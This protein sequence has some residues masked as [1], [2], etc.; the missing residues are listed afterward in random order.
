MKRPIIVTLFLLLFIFLTNLSKAQT[1]QKY[2]KSGN[3]NLIDIVFVS[4]SRGFTVGYNK[5]FMTTDTGK[6]WN[7]ILSS[8]NN[9]SR[10][11]FADANNG[12]IIGSNDLV[13]KTTDAGDNWSLIRTGNSD[14]DLITLF[15]K[16]KDTL[17]VL[18]PDDMDTYKYG[19]YL[20]YTYNG[21]STWNRRSTG[22]TQ[23]IRSMYMWNKNKGLMSTLTS[24]VFQTTDGFVNYNVNWNANNAVD[25][26]VIKDSVVIIVS[27]NGQIYRSSDYGNN[28]KTINSGTSD[29]LWGLHFAND[30]IGMACGAKGTLLYTDN[31]GLS[32]SKMTTNT[33]LTFSKVFVFNKYYAWAVVNSGSGDS[34]DIYKFG[35]EKY[36]VQKIN[37]VKGSVIADVVNNC[38]K[39]SKEIGPSEVLIKAVPGPYYSYTLANGNYE[40]V[41]P[42]TGKFTISTILP[43]K[44]GG[45][46]NQCDTLKNHSV[47]FK[48]FENIASGKN[49]FF[50]SDSSIKL[51]INI[52]SSRKR[53]CFK[54]DNTITYKNIGTKTVDSSKVQLFYSSLTDI[55]SAD[56]SYKKANGVVTFNTGK[57]LPGQGGVIHVVDSVLCGDPD[58]RGLLACMRVLITPQVI[59]E[60]K[61]W[62]SSWVKLGIKCVKDTLAIVKLVNDGKKPMSDS[63]SL[64]IFLNENKVDIKKYKLGAHDSL[65]YELYPAG[66]VI[67]TETELKKQHPY[68]QNIR[69]FKERCGDSAGYFS[70]QEVIQHVLQEYPS[71]EDEV[72]LAIRDSYDPNDISVSPQGHGP[73]HFIKNNNKLRYTIRF[74]NTGTDTAYDIYVIDT[75]P[76]ELNIASLEMLGSSHKYTY[77]VLSGQKKNVLRFDFKNIF[78]VDSFA[79]EKKSHGFVSF[80]L[81]M[82]DSLKKGT[83]IRNFA[84]IY[85][86][87]NPP[88]KTNTAFNTIYDTTFT[89]L[90]PNIVRNCL[91]RFIKIPKDTLLC[92]ESQ[93]TALF[94]T[95]GTYQPQ[96]KTDDLALQFYRQ[97]DSM[98]MISTK[99][100]GKFNISYELK[101]CEN[102]WRDTTLVTFWKN[103]SISVKDSLYCGSI[104]DKIYFNCFNCS[105]LWNGIDHS[106]T[107]KITKPGKYW[108]K[109]SNLCKSIS[110]SF[111]LSYL[112][113]LKLDLGNDTL[114]CDQ[115]K[116]SFNLKLKPGKFLWSDSDT[117][118]TKVITQTGRYTVYFENQCNSLSD[119]ITVNHQRSPAIQLGK[120]TMHCNKVN[121]VVNLDSLK[122]EYNIKWWDGSNASVRTFTDT[123]TYSITLQNLCGTAGDEL[124]ISVS[125]ADFTAN[126][127]C[128][129]DS[130]AF[131][132]S[133]IN[134]QKFKWKFGDGTNSTE[135]NPKYLYKNG[136]ISI[137]YNVSLVTTNGNC[138][139]SVVNGVTINSSPISDFDWTFA[140]KTFEFTAKQTGNTIYNWNFGDGDSLIASNKTIHTYQNAPGSFTV[141]LKTENAASCISETC[142]T[143]LLGGLKANVMKGIKIYP[144]PNSGNF[145]IEIDKPEKNISVEV[146]NVLGEKLGTENL[147]QTNSTIQMQLAPG[148]YWIKVQ[149]GNN[150]FHEKVIAN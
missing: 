50:K 110:D 148:I 129:Y 91:S 71:F 2:A 86:D 111:E 142:K 9:F 135:E 147:N 37:T 53:R 143:I 101:S 1:W 75:L 59:V 93:F 39:D 121:H 115:G 109:V 141:C 51:E 149:N 89:S 25:T 99:R 43:S 90:N 17:Y 14:D 85:F 27:N 80:D 134:A 48:T 103:P 92:D 133:S 31:G 98:A 5:V 116:L 54:N 112:P 117:N 56:K 96:W 82:I 78:L 61:N 46:K 119:S 26:R 41:L 66:K 21:G 15:P 81:S 57:L 52:A 146:F 3:S 138:S 97:N 23:T 100:E 6:T 28:W 125:K 87:F 30:S 22:S 42:D 40:L 13:L 35:S 83:E 20:E 95:K 33:N 102:I 34:I 113:Y 137:T 16:S 64:V 24:G 106:D 47:Y 76:G 65:K 69:V 127:A 11:M 132:N 144:N 139:D 7:R 10:I 44:Y 12:F 67:F 107:L 63:A 150:I 123:G 32:W 105:Y 131:I 72:C 130:V 70:K 128:D 8:Y 145:K 62:D 19:N 60:N 49:F 104:Q 55:V 136:G 29:I 124:K 36:I 74:Q 4:K 140:G 38:K 88:V 126:D 118:S 84:D 58:V 77:K 68:L 108:V 94:K 73:K 45:D 79:N 114:L 122:N 18:G 120:D